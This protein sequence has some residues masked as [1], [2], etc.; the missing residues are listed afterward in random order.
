M[1]TVITDRLYCSTMCMIAEGLEYFDNDVRHCFALSTAVDTTNSAWK[2][3]QL[4]FSRGGLGLHRL[5]EHSSACYI[6]SL[7]M[8]GMCSESNRHLLNPINQFNEHVSNEE[9]VTLEAIRETPCRQI[10]R[11]HVCTALPDRARLISVSSPHAAAWLSTAPS[12]G[13]NLQLE[14]SEFQAAIQWWLG[15]DISG[16][17]GATC[18]H[19]PAHSL[20]PLGHHALT[21]KH[22]GD[23]VI[24]HDRLQ[25]VFACRVM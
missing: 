11:Q 21:C 25:D 9:M 14:P 5:S 4:S 10:G 12:P 19:C 1:R 13:L 15:V 18:P 17:Q 6:A 2:Q 7:S 22:G 24:R 8:A 20:D 16:S 3:A 23:V